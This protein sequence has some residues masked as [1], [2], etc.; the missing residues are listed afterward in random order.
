MAKKPKFGF[1]EVEGT[2][3]D[4]FTWLQIRSGK[5]RKQRLE[6]KVGHVCRYKGFFSGSKDSE[7]L[8]TLPLVLPSCR[9]LNQKMNVPHLTYNTVEDLNL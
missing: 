1:V 3:T 2:K 6:I 7:Q 4:K 5:V 8:L 9:F